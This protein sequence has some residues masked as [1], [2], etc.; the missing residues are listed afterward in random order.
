MESDKWI[1]GAPTLLTILTCGLIYLLYRHKLSH[2]MHNVLLKMMHVRFI[3]KSLL[4][5]WGNLPDRGWVL[6]LA[7]RGQRQMD[8]YSL[9]MKDLCSEFVVQS[10][11]TTNDGEVSVPRMQQSSMLH[12]KC[13]WRP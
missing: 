6:W 5:W 3:R 11:V 12:R 10:D 13:K 8:E 9:F 2:F 1:F 4:R 7:V